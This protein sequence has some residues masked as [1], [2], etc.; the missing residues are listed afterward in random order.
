MTPDEFI[1][2]AVAVTV[3]IIFVA[4]VAWGIWDAVTTHKLWVKER[5][6][7]LE[8]LRGKKQ[9]VSKHD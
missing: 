4:A 3:C 1:S 5:E 7:R 8:M 9:E 6:A 2:C